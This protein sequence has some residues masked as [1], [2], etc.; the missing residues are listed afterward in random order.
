MTTKRKLSPDTKK[1][2]EEHKNL[3]KKK[4]LLYKIYVDFYKSLKP[5]GVPKGA[6]VEIGSGGGFLKEIIPE[7]V[8]SDVIEGP[9][10]DKVFFA[11]KMPFKNKSVSAFIMIDVLHHIK[12][13]RK[14]FNEMERCLKK[15][16]KIIMI[17]PFKS[18]WGYFIYKYL[19]YEHFD[20][21]SGWEVKGKGRMSD[22]NTALPW[23][24]FV[25]DRHIFE[26]EFP[27]LKIIKVE[28]HSPFRYLLSGGLTK[29]QFAPTFTYP[30][31]KFTEDKLLSPL[32]NQI[33]MF[34][35]IELQ[36]KD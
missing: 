18:L 12:D 1:A 5:N 8:T 35:T 32:K 28:G 9:G 11:E 4:G 30:F 33:G 19:H 6:I 10:I 22:S 29:P 36:K 20:P 25:R 26:K 15:D 7:V 16:G 14:A 2:L 17:E 13:P 23:I 27:N 24:I 3:I 34:V 21:S 31:I